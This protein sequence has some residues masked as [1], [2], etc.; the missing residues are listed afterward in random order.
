MDKIAPQTQFFWDPDSQNGDI[1]SQSLKD[2]HVLLIIHG[3]NN[4]F[5]FAIKSIHEVNKS[6][7]Q[8][9]NS[10]GNNL[11]DLVIGYIWPAYDNFLDYSL[12]A[13][14]VDK[15]K[16]RVRKH[17]M[18]LYQ[19]TPHIDVIAHSLGNKVVLEAL[20]FYPA[21]AKRPIVKHFYALAPAVDAIS[22]QKGKSLHQSTLNIESMF[23]FH[24]SNDDVLKFVYPLTSGKEALGI[25]INPPFKKLE[26]TIQFI[27][28]TKLVQGHGYYFQAEPIYKFIQRVS[29][30]KNPLPQSAKKVC[31][32]KDGSVKVL[33]N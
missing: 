16:S 15:L 7:S 18:D 31:L 11:Y 3:Y 14:H 32:A 21:D 25:E 4:T 19:V 22:I 29:N 26:N 2:K 27:D 13:D 28:C 6:I 23:V 20:N 12:A 9:K 24:S 33:K 5:D 10:E 1:D 8:M 17:L 30:H